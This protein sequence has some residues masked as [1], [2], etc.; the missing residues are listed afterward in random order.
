MKEESFQ[1]CTVMSISIR[2]MRMCL[3]VHQHSAR[4]RAGFQLQFEQTLCMNCSARA[5]FSMQS[6]TEALTDQ[7]LHGGCACSPT[8]VQLD[9]DLLLTFKHNSGVFTLLEKDLLGIWDCLRINAV[10]YKREKKRSVAPA[11]HLL[12][13]LSKHCI[14]KK[15]S[16]N[17]V[18]LYFN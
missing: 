13:Q 8:S 6:V 2:T 15:A 4:S 1:P 18:W 12:L 5:A 11:H 3:S 9:V 7:Q 14:S 16:K 10:F 17:F